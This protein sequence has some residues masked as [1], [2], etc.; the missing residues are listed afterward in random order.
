MKAGIRELGQRGIGAEISTLNFRSPI[1]PVRISPFP[2]S[3]ACSLWPVA[4]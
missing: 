3:E 2:P 4:C 1:L